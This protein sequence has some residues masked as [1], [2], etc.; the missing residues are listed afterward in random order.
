MW[1]TNPSQR[2]NKRDFEIIRME[3]EAEAWIKVLFLCSSF[4]YRQVPKQEYKKTL[5]YGIVFG[6]I[7]NTLVVLLLSWLNLI[8]Y[9]NMG[10]FK[11]GPFTSWTPINWTLIFGLFFYLLPVRKLFI[12]AVIIAFAAFSY[13]VGLIFE[14]FGVFRYIGFWRYVAPFLFL[15]WYSTAAYV[16]IRNRGIALRE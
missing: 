6:G 2:I 8:E 1:M 12:A 9:K 7:G 16:Y 4:F 5:L 14:N 13:G 3:A 15:T 11:I 10:P